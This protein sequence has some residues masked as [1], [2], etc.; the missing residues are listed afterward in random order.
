MRAVVVRQTS[1][2]V[3]IPVAHVLHVAQPVVD[4]PEL[5]VAHRRRHAAA[6]VVAADDDVTDLQHFDRE[7][8]DGQA[9]QVAVHDHVRDV[10]VDEDLTG[11]QPE[12]LVRGHAAVGAADP[13]IARRLLPRQAREEIGVGARHGVGP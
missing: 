13:Q 5:V 2:L 1:Q 3:A 11:Q 4:Q 7:L 9:I 8:N 6:A 12:D 10:A